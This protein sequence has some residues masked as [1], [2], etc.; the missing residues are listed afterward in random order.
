V[1]PHG[2]DRP[3]KNSSAYSRYAAVIERFNNLYNTAGGKLAG[4]VE[5]SRG[6]RFCEIVADK[7]LSQIESPLIPQLQKI[8]AGTRDTNLLYHVLDTGERTAV[9]HYS[10]GD[11]PILADLGV[12]DKIFSFYIKTA[13]FDR[14]VRVDFWSEPANAV[15]TAERIAALILPLC[16]HS[17]YGFPAPLIEADVRAKLSERDADTLHDQLVDRVGI[18]PSLLKLRRENRPF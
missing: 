5:D 17:S 8:L 3:P 14:P 7:V 18:T 6:R 15:K 1:V 4:C 10:S 2:N 16:G 12:K 9:F 11:N 13:E